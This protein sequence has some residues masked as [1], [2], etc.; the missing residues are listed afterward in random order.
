M[1]PNEAV[2]VVGT[3]ETETEAAVSVSNALSEVIGTY[4][5]G[6]KFRAILDFALFRKFR[7]Y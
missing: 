1:K 6:G 7:R 5:T 4:R 2:K 3:E